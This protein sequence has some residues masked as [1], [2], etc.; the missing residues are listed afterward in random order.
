MS[1][2]TIV[3]I[4]R[5]CQDHKSN[6]NFFLL[7]SCSTMNFLRSKKT[8]GVLT[9]SAMC[10]IVVNYDMIEIARIFSLHAPYSRELR[11]LDSF[12]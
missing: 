12:G 6:I 10:M 3:V 9:A 8:I 1:L 2:E 11:T 4:I 7:V 5:S